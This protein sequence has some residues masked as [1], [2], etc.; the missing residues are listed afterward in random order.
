MSLTHPQLAERIRLAMEIAKM[1]SQSE[2]ARA[3]GIKPQAV[4]YLLD[5]RNNATGS[6]HL[7][8][9]AEALG[10][11]AVWLAT[12]LGEPTDQQTQSNVEP[13]PDV[14]RGILYPL[15]TWVQAGVW[16]GNC[17]AFTP[18]QAEQWYMS[19]HNLGPRGYVLRVRGE[20]MT[21]P[22]GRYSFPEGMLLFVNPDKDPTPGQFVIAR[23]DADNEATFKRYTLVDGK[24]YLEALNPDWPHKYIEMRPGDT[25]GGIVV[26]ASFGK[27]P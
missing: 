13:G 11:N 23:R 17:E 15:I 1:P 18:Y 5:P 12:G 4:Q 22:Q 27:L 21:N 19:P 9:I 16:N 25:F 6:K 20:S 7:V 10:V 24:P 26:D 8:K 3:V 14:N 2:L